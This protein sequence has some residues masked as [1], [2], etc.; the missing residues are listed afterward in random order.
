MV[1]FHQGASKLLFKITCLAA[2]VSLL[3][4]YIHIS[5]GHKA[6]FSLMS[7]YVAPLFPLTV[8]L[9][10]CCGQILAPSCSFLL[11]NSFQTEKPMVTVFFS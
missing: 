10:A 7:S 11:H 1:I 4:A 8:G 9:R 3:F 6:A 5:D 2:I